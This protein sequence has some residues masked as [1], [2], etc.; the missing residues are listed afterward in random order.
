ME[1]YFK[2]TNGNNIICFT[3]GVTVKY[4]D[5]APSGVYCGIDL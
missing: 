3:D 1:I 5:C 4:T 2:E